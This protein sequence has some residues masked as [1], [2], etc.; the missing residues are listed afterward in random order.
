V[1]CI[2]RTV[3]RIASAALL[4]GTALLILAPAALAAD[5]SGLVGRPTDKTVTLF[6]FGLLGFFTALVIVLSMIQGRLDTRKQR[7]RD[8]LERMRR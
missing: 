7:H 2:V 1:G 3:R 5:G 4:A 6:C 8:E